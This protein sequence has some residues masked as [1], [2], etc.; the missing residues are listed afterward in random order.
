M[1]RGVHHLDDEVRP[2]VRIHFALAGRQLDIRQPILAMPELGGD[3]FL[4]ERMLRSGRDGN[5][6][7]VSQRNHPQCVLQ[8][9]AGSYVSRDDGDG[10]NVQFRRIQRQHQGQRIVSSGIGVEN[11]FLCSG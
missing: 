8:S 5:V 6:A 3:E 7:A 9:L 2:E 11:D 4:K 10:A 1:R